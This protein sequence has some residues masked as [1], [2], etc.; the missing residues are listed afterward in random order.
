MRSLKLSAHTNYQRGHPRVRLCL[1]NFAHFA[2]P[3]LARRSA[4]LSMPAPDNTKSVGPATTPATDDTKFVG[5][6]TTL[7]VPP[8]CPPTQVAAFGASNLFR[9]ANSY[10]EWVL[11]LCSRL[12]SDIL[13]YLQSGVS[14]PS[15]PPSYVPLWDHY[16]R[17]SICAAVDQW[18][19]LPGLSLSLLPRCPQRPQDF[20][21]PMPNSPNAFLQFCDRFDNNAQL[22][23]DS[24]VTTDS[25]LASHLLA[26]MPPSLSAWRTTFVNSQGTSGTL[27]PAANI[28]DRIYRES[29][30][31][32]AEAPAVAAATF[33]AHEAST[34]P[35]LRGHK[36]L[37]PAVA[38]PAVIKMPEPTTFT[39][40]LLATPSPF[41]KLAWLLDSGANCHMANTSTLFLTLRLFTGPPVA[42]VAG[43][44]PSIGCG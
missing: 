3:G 14:H 13:E 37:S 36:K 41:H 9:N 11:T 4:Q 22:L 40:C 8:P 29:K 39:A 20:P 31:C 44:L 1:S 6:A 23:A 2:R 19:V 17:T 35:S 32:P 28:L 33:R 26:R 12:P 27:P 21:E 18:M 38:S 10:Q 15:W 24:N 7:A 42:G 30:A 5:P 25:L 34:G 43:S 16:T